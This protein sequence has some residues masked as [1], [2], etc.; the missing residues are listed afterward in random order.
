MV[1][2]GFRIRYNS[3]IIIVKSH[4]TEELWLKIA[5]LNLA[6]VQR[7]ETKATFIT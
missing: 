7:Q 2:Y 6:L 1:R 3:T 4:E 5:A